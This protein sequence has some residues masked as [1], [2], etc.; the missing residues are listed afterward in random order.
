[1]KIWIIALAG[2]WAVTAQG[3]PEAEDFVRVVDLKD[4]R[5][6]LQT[7][8]IS[9]RGR[10]GQEVDLIGAVH[11]ADAAYY[12][13]LNERFTGY[14]VVLFEMVG[15]PNKRLPAKEA[16]VANEEE[17][18][19]TAKGSADSRMAWLGV[20]YETMRSK[21]KLTGQMDEINYQAPN[22][23]H[24]D[25]EADEFFE[26][27]EKQGESFLGLWW[28]ATVA[29]MNGTREQPMEHQLG[30]VEILEM[31][32]KEDGSNELKRVVARQF[33]QIEVLLSDVE[34]EQGTVILAG[35]NK[36]ALKAL[37]EQVKLGKRKIAIFYGAA[38]LPDMLKRMTRQ[39]YVVTNQQWLT[40]WKIAAPQPP[41][42]KP[43]Q[44]K[45]EPQ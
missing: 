4:G 30:L 27:Q 36:V 13:Q 37:K 17:A 40:A 38:H 14:E 31:L 1:M 41:Q 24:A 8:V 16:K 26:A 33:D 11:V 21:L 44:R 45:T 35:R 28:K 20:L 6:Q 19:K 15:D 34:G 18:S 7:A 10:A 12:Q 42:E 22:F 23:V 43:Q 29:S 5:T 39:G 9:V 25:M 2:L 3:A 32:M